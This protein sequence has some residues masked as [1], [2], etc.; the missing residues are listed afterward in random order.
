V[1]VDAIPIR[2][3]SAIHTFKYG[4]EKVKSLRVGEG[5][6]TFTDMKNGKN[7]KKKREK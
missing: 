6:A 3:V 4:N 5:W 7:K 1:G 2:L